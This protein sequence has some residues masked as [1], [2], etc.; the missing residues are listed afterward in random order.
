MKQK[1]NKLKEKISRREFLLDITK[2]GAFAGIYGIG[3]EFNSILNNKV[4]VNK[5]KRRMKTIQINDV[6][7]NFER[8]PLVK[9]MGFKGGYITEKWQFAALLESESGYQ[10]IGLCSPSIL[11]SDRIVALSHT[12]SAGYAIMFLML[13]FR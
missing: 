10:D 9:P 13:I 6:D 7:L 5:N 3:K 8:E 11:W 1:I 2:V 4:E 12:E